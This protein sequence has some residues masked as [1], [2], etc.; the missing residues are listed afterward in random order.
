MATTTIGFQKISRALLD[1]RSNAMAGRNRCN[2][3]DRAG[4]SD[5]NEHQATS[6]AMENLP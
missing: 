2:R 5:V 4:Y 1:T 6:T 3:H